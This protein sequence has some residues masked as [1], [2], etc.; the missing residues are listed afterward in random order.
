MD[1]QIIHN[2]PPH[3][4]E[5]SEGQFLEALGQPSILPLKGADSSR[6]RTLCT[7]LHGNEPSG[8]QAVFQFLKQGA[9]PAVDIDII[10]ASVGTALTEPRFSHRMLPSKRDLNRCFRPPFD[11]DEGLL[12]RQILDFIRET[13]PEC[14]IDLHNTSGSGPAFGVAVKNDADHLALTSLWTNDMILTDLRLGALMELSERNVP[15]VTI[16]CGGAN[17]RPSLIIATEGLQRYFLNEHVRAQPGENYAVTC[18]RNPV[19]LEVRPGFRVAYTDDTYC[20]ADVSLHTNADQLNY[21]SLPP[22]EPIAR[23]G[24]EG[25]KALQAN[26]HLGEN[27][28]EEYFCSHDQKLYA[29][30]TLK[31]FMVTTSKAIAERDCLLYFIE[32]SSS[33]S[34]TS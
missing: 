34:K 32:C 25:L 24:P 3:W 21:G 26:N 14:L 29:Q 27:V 23:L 5:G 15:T 8:V 20:D 31:L 28:L 13:Q 1:L 9:Q 10:I 4:L 12:A 6:R 30:H 7:L 11:G 33:Q 19:R 2:I 16:E 22:D 18:Y 17:D